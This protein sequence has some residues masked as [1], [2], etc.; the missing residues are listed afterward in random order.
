MKRTA[1]WVMW[2]AFIVTAL[3]L[4]AFGSR[5]T[6]ERAMRIYDPELLEVL[7]EQVT[8]LAVQSADYSLDML[9]IT[10]LECNCSFTLG[11]DERLWLFHAEPKIRGVDRDGPSHGILKKGNVIVSIDDM[12]IT[13]RKAGIRFAN[14]AAGEPI[15]LTV[16]HRGR[17]RSVT[18]VPRPIPEVEVPVEFTFHRSGDSSDMKI[19]LQEP[20]SSE[21]AR[22]IEQLSKH[23]A[24]IGETVRRIGLPNPDMDFTASMPR[25]WMGFGLLF[26]GSIREKDTDKPAE[27]RFNDPP[28]IKS[29]QP[30]S[31]AEEAGFEVDDVLLE[32]DGLKLDSGKGGD[33]FSRMEP[34]QTVEWKVRR[35]E[36]TFNVKTKAAE[37]PRPERAEA[38]SLPPEPDAQW[39]LRYTGT[40]G[41][42]EIEVRGGK[43]VRVE[44]DEEKG[45]IVIRS[46]D[47]VV[48]L[49]PKNER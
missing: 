49:K 8:E 19:E 1:K 33:R 18:I 36:K 15:R 23:A 13:T 47:S 28:S 21:L 37:R 6:D 14:L 35:G 38:P 43:S 40:L 31:P 34:G 7:T 42:T 22:S 16:R 25:G 41:G 11:K 30:G 10:S 12:L 45:E 2:C 39:P 20:A 27:W 46:G 26:S 24:K 4:A 17:T 9:G 3:P 29:I 48:R 32:I 44:T 5:A